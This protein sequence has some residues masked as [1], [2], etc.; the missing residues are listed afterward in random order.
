MYHSVADEVNARWIDPR[1]HVPPAIFKQQIEF[2][3]ERKKVIGLSEL[4]SLLLQGKTPDNN[5][6]VITFDDGYLD[7]LTIAAPIL[8]RYGLKATLFLPTGLI[9]RGETQWVDQV[10]SIFKYRRINE[11]I[12]PESTRTRFDLQNP[13]QRKEGYQI[14]CNSLLIAS[15]KIRKNHLNKLTDQLQPSKIPPRLTM[16]WNDVNTLLTEFQCFQIGGHSIEH[17]DLTSIAEQNARDEL[18]DC[19]LRIEQATD[20]SPHYFSFPYGRTSSK[21]RNISAEVGFKSAFGGD[22]ND[23][24]ITS[25]TDIYALP[26]VEAPASM[27]Q[28]DL[29]TRTSNTGIWR[30]IGR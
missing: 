16:T 14:V 6:I 3:A 18:R 5:T 27:K 15:A 20:I 7:N 25:E 4:A 29:L 12:W 1:D 13:M 21:L 22:G 24:I 9:D 10:Y 30:R 8:E 11:L 17:T 2:L 23:P 28:F 26:R 19:M